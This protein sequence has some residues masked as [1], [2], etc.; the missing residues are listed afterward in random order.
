MARPE[1]YKKEYINKVGEY[2]EENTDEEIEVVSL[3]N[4]E[5][6]YEKLEQK[7]KVKLPTLE[8]FALFIGVSKRVLYLWEEKYPEFMHAL[9]KIRTEQHKRLLNS[10]LS[11]DYNSTIAKLILSSNH[12][13]KERTDQTTNDKDIPQPIYGGQS[14]K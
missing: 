13:M 5:K 12:G 3:R 14:G 2:L 11:G 1:E 9:D 10:G 4:E 8:G 7:L 6:G